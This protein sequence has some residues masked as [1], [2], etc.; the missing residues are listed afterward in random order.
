MNAGKIKAVL[1]IIV[2]LL[3]VALACAWVTGGDTP[4][5]ENTSNNE[6]IV[7]PIATAD[8]NKPQPT[9][10]PATPTP[11]T[12]TP[13]TP[14]PQQNNGNGGNGEVNVANPTPT[15][16]AAPSATPAP[17]NTPDPA[18]TAAPQVTTAPTSGNPIANGSFTSKTGTGLEMRA[19]WSAVATGTNTATVTVNVYAISYSLYLTENDSGLK[20]S[21]G[22]QYTSAATAGLS[23][24]NNA[25]KTTLLGTKSFTIDTS[26]GKVDLPLAIEWHYMGSYGGVA[27]DV[28]ECGGNVKFGG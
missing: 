9:S 10:A 19:E 5:K 8:P 12:P 17:G 18:A 2:F 25:Q 28:I 24:S 1:F 15:P 13:Q 26:K 23:Y 14:A 7:V 4:T 22:N 11:Q 27:I 20:I 6:P 3:V 16:T 21:L